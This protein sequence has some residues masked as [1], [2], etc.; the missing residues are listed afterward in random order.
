MSVLW[1]QG[2]YRKKSKNALV[3]KHPDFYYDFT[4]NG[5]RNLQNIAPFCQIG[6]KK[7]IMPISLAKQGKIGQIREENA[8][9]SYYVRLLRKES[10]SFRPILRSFGIIPNH[11]A[12][13]SEDYYRFTT[14]H[15]PRKFYV[16]KCFSE[17]IIGS[18]KPFFYYI[19][20]SCI[21]RRNMIK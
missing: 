20:I 14:N 6:S 13:S 3:V 15:Y 19:S 1:K 21:F 4:A 10:R 18:E 12:R 11:A 5:V 9:V 16:K 17:S 8:Y 7:K 2:M